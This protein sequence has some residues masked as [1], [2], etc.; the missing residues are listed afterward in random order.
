MS[1][2]GVFRFK[3]FGP[4]EWEGRYR[5]IEGRAPVFHVRKY[6]GRWMIQIDVVDEDCTS[7]FN[8]RSSPDVERLT[9]TINSIKRR[10]NGKNGGAFLINE[11]GQVLVPAHNS[12]PFCVGETRGLLLFVNPETGQ[13]IDLSND[14]RLKIGDP[15]DKPYVGMAYN[16]SQGSRIY[17]QLV[18]GGIAAPPTQDQN[19]IRKLRKLRPYGPVRF[20]VNPYGLVL[21]K[22]R[23]GEF[24]SSD[25]TY[26]AVYVG[27]IDYAKWFEKEELAECQAS[28]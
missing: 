12:P 25:D 2:K 8:A 28:S 27:R 10:H 11:F 13:I 7:T 19:L 5:R 6:D 23:K 14:Q 9:E 26:R 16:L 1:V 18:S 21:T 20:I 3:A 24:R 15:W 22:I 17:S 4:Q